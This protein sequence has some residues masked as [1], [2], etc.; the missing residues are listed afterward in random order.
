MQLWEKVL[1]NKKR[2]A[3]LVGCVIL[4][5]GVVP[6]VALT[7]FPV[8]GR[9]IRIQSVTL[10]SQDGVDIKALVYSSGDDSS[11]RPG[12]VVAHGYCG[13]KHFMQALSVELAKGGYTVISIDFRGH[14]ASGG[15]LSSRRGKN[16]TLEL[17]LDAAVTYLRHLGYVDRLGLVGH[18]M[19]G[20]ASVNYAESHPDLVN[21]TLSIGMISLDYDF[22]KVSNLMVAIGHDQLFSR[23][24]GL[25]LLEN[26]TGKDDVAAGTTYGSFEDGTACKFVQGRFSD[27]LL[28]VWDA[29]ILSAMVG[30]FRASFGESNT[31]T[32]PVTGPV[33]AFFQQV[34]TFGGLLLVF[35]GVVA[36]RDFTWK[37]GDEG[38]DHGRN[39]V[40]LEVSAK[41]MVGHSFPATLLGLIFTI[42]FAIVLV[43]LTPVD[44]FEMLYGLS[45]GAALALLLQA[46]LLQGC[47]SG[48]TGW[49][50]PNLFK[51][52]FGPDW[53]RSLQLGVLS[54]LLFT[55]IASAAGSWNSI[56]LYLT[57]REVGVVFGVTILLFPFLLVK[58]FWIRTIQEKLPAGRGGESETTG[59][60]LKT[61]SKM[62]G[63]G[64]LLDNFVWLP[65]TIATWGRGIEIGFL[66]LSLTA[67]MLFSF[68]LQVL[69]NW[70]YTFSGMDRGTR[71]I[72]T[73]TIFS[74]VVYAWMIVN[75]FPFSVS[76]PIF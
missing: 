55:G 36:L 60:K 47:S 40:E 23:A 18:S 11:S 10:T 15:F 14:G 44:N 43:D 73:S 69:V 39:W 56:P 38:E 64:L 9:P 35:V 29:D 70:V 4:A 46:R 26:Y 72:L 42:P 53:A 17:D 57:A 27:H 49:N 16:S 5:A 22:S 50:L 12:V 65:V 67:L 28:E 7:F 62:V 59:A 68:V 8:P 6:V 52:K 19:G 66:A 45:I 1:R 34:A 24:D 21:A 2:A 74:C 54:A 48:G 3:A 58:E 33:L 41:K 25:R 75:F 51:S 30:W 20:R 32:S 13:N 31:G 61:Y 71:S 37:D 76:Q 63:L